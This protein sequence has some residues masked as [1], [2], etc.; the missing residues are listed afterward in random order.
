MILN[1]IHTHQ[2]AGTIHAVALPPQTTIPVLDATEVSGHG[3]RQYAGIESVL[4]NA[5]PSSV[6][7]L[8]IFLSNDTAK[9]EAILGQLKS[10]FI[11]LPLVVLLESR[12]VEIAVELMQQGVFAVLTHPLEHQKL[13]TTI[14]AAV[15][16]SN[17]NQAEVDRSRDASLR[18]GEATDKEMEVLELM[19][20]G[21]KNKESAERLG[22]TVRAV[23]DR[24]FRL[25]KKV[26]VDSVAELIALSV[27]A[28][29][30]ERGL[31]AGGVN[32][33]GASDQKHC[34]KGIEVWEPTEDDT[35]LVLAHSCYRD[36]VTFRDASRS[37]SF[38]RGEGLPGNVWEHRVPAFLKELITADFLR[39]TAARA[40][41]ITTAAA[42]P[43]FSKGK[44]RSVVL[45]LLDSRNQFRAAFESWQVNHATSTMRLDS[46]TYINCEKLRQLSQ[47]LHLPVGHGLAGFVAEQ[48]QP[49][50]G[51]RF[52]EDGHA[53]RG[54]ALSAEKLISG[55][56][57]PLTDSGADT[58]NVF[59]LFNSESTPMFSLL[60]T[61][62]ASGD[63]I[64]M[65]AEYSDGV[66]SLA[67]QRPA[68]ARP[69]ES[70]IAGKAWT[71]AAPVV[72]ST[73]AE[74]DAIIHGSHTSAASMGV[75]IPTI[76]S[77][78]VAAVTVLAN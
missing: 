8:L 59:T 39:C 13:L 69:A 48:E 45:I 63:N 62:K 5:A 25:M 32:Y 71:S 60:Q 56:A 36:A 65:S 22:I 21:C 55:V 16:Q 38:R 4:E 2:T 61:W 1:A 29:H 64:V 18:I 35:R 44:V 27:T 17:T 23:E 9:N 72:A 6:G 42:F 66:S 28:R 24:R 54:I 52:S 7:C 19:L 77:G 46:G 73:G 33:R 15:E 70:G 75:A 76:I 68:P 10:H 11:S 20:K 49:Y 30:F 78:K 57:L 34:V 67:S 51:S 31:T 50:I 26:G 53:V 74:T 14:N 37:L 58:S 3:I 40:V 47:F 41:G 43:I 12:S